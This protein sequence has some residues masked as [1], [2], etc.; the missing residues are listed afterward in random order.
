MITETDLFNLFKHPK[1][2]ETYKN[3]L[4]LSSKK[5]P[6]INYIGVNFNN[7]GDINSVKFYFAFFHKLTKNEI[8]KFIP[9]T[10]DFDR[11]YHLWDE[12]KK[13]SLEH[14]G[15]TF[16]IKFKESLIPTIGFH[17]RLK[18]IKES[19]D[20]I[21][22][23]KNI[24]F[25]LLDVGTRPGINYEYTLESVLRKKYYYLEKPTHKE[26]IARMFNKPFA[27]DASLIEYTEADQISKVNIWRFDYSND[28]LNRPNY[29]NS[30]EMRIINLIKEKY[31]LI[32]ISD[33]FY[34]DDL[35]K[36]TYFFNTVNN[37]TN[38]PFDRKENFN[39]DTIKL[40]L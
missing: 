6:N 4:S 16:E 10:N 39:I 33:G 25:N 38:N 28:N 22:Y 9:H 30:S 26:Y 8:Q 15:C 29:F 40:F 17:Y 31:G 13:R 27:Q 21:G 23:P 19:Y 34:K 36:A 14:T 5:Y 18:P 37:T 12:S 3:Y 11:Y 2:Q 1:V 7:K 24:P 35:I 20:L 32:S